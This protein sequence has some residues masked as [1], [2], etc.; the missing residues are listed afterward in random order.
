MKKPLMA[1]LIKEVGDLGD[2]MMLG[3]PYT[4]GGGVINSG[5]DTFSSPEVTQDLD[6]FDTNGSIDGGPDAYKNMEDTDQKGSPELTFSPSIAGSATNINP[7]YPGDQNGSKSTNK[8]LNP[9]THKDAIQKLKYKVTPDE[10]I[11]GITA[12]LRDMV[13][14]RP[15]VAKA[16][17][18]KNLQSDP[19]FYSKLKFLNIDDK[20]NES[21]KY[22]TPQEIA[23]IKIMRNLA[24]KKAGKRK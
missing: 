14:K 16:K 19:K 22:N 21:L 4:A 3:L 2:R 13:F 12:E 20:L 10:I 15:D 8:D 1:K 23:I 5:L 24:E 18:I 17:V 11:T 7:A 9:Y 6:K